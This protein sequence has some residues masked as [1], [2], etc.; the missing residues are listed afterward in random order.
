VRTVRRRAG[1]VLVRH[2]GSEAFEQG[3]QRL[4]QSAL[5][6]AADFAATGAIHIESVAFADAVSDSNPVDDR[7]TFSCG[8]VVMFFPAGEV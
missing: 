3:N 6:D 8:A 1:A 4:V 5:P 2:L 7:V